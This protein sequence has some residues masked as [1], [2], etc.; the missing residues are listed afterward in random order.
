MSLDL[1]RSKFKRLECVRKEF[2]LCIQA[3]VN[4]H[5]PLEEV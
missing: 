2:D 5:L 1:H 4:K 3:D